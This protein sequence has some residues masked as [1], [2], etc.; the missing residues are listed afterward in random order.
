MHKQPASVRAFTLLELLVVIAIIAVLAALL[1]PA[2]VSAKARAKRTACISNLRQINVGIRMYSDD[3]S[4]KTP[5]L[6]GGLTNNVITPSAPWIAYKSLM[7]NYVGLHAASSD[8]D[9]LFACP[10]D[11][12]YYDTRLGG[13]GYVAQPRHEQAFTDYSSYSFNGVNLLTATNPANGGSFLGIGGQSLGS[14]KEPART[15]LVGD[16]P[17]W[18]PYS[19]HEA[20]HAGPII[21]AP[22][23]FNDAKDVMSFM[24]GHVSYINIYWDTNRISFGGG[25]TFSLACEYDPPAGYDYKWSGD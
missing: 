16:A 22:V 14:V 19:W 13:P 15:V 12:F 23:M 7:K 9:K 3:A 18:L 21:N 20:K 10:A 24:D 4:D 1:L 2:I 11:I 17:A 5:A 8:Q 6:Q 25:S